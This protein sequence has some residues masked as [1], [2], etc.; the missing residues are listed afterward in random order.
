MVYQKLSLLF[1]MFTPKYHNV[2][3]IPTKLG[4]ATQ[5]IPNLS[6]QLHLNVVA[7]VE[8]WIKASQV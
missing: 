5:Q 3:R 7:V 8:I 4:V 1:E 2:S 6:A